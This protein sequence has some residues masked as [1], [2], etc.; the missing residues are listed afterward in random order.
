MMRDRQ[1]VS[2]M[3]FKRIAVCSHHAFPVLGVDLQIEKHVA[4][5]VGSS[6][7][8]SEERWRHH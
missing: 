7:E 1:L 8:L 5:P 3:P 4:M 2:D 6:V